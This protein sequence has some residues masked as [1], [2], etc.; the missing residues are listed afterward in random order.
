M[1]WNFN[2]HRDDPHTGS[3]PE[4]DA[5]PPTSM[6][7]IGSPPGAP[8][9]WVI[10]LQ[11]VILDG[12]PI[13]A[14]TRIFPDE[15]PSHNQTRGRWSG[16]AE[17]VPELGLPAAVVKN[18]ALG[19]M[20]DQVRAAL[21][22]YKD[23]AWGETDFPA[24][25]DG[26][27]DTWLEWSEIT[28]TMGVD[29]DDTTKRRGPGRHPLPDEHLA[30]VA[31]YYDEALRNNL[32]A[33]RHIEQKMRKGEESLPVAQWIRKARERGFLTSTPKP[34]QRGGTITPNAIAVLRG[35][36]FFDSDSATEPEQ[37]GTKE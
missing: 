7:A 9:G 23:P 5:E 15:G 11:F 18:L 28:E 37:E 35:I 8:N 24:D 22:H 27:P 2:I 26:P 36:G 12:H 19:G 29:P 3:W 6:W 31:Y 34:G 32:K 1:T 20:E 30:K 25:A 17:A 13:L 16:E 14:E 4:P 33:H 21:A 10:G